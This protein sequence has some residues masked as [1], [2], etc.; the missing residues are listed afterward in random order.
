MSSLFGFLMYGYALSGYTHKV[1]LSP[2][3]SYWASIHRFLQEQTLDCTTLLQ[4]IQALQITWTAF[5]LRFIFLL[6]LFFFSVFL[7]FGLVLSILRNHNRHIHDSNRLWYCRKSL[8]KDGRPPSPETGEL[9]PL[10]HVILSSQAKKIRP[11]CSHSLPASLI[12][13]KGNAIATIEWNNGPK[14]ISFINQSGK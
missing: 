13:Y 3:L 2:K 12:F 1:Q 4:I 5:P 9:I 10:A 8:R 14:K 6:C 11:S 7:V